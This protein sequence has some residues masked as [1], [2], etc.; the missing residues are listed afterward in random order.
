[1]EDRHNKEL[2]RE[3]TATHFKLGDDPVVYKRTSTLPDPT[4]SM[5]NYTGVLNAEVCMYAIIHDPQRGRSSMARA[6]FR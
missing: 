6:D 2:K 3:L 4:G 5:S 1:M